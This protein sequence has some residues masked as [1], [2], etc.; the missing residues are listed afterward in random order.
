MIPGI[1]LIYSR[2]SSK[3]LM[4]KSVGRLIYSDNPYKLIVEVDQGISDFYY[5]LI[6][7]S[8]R[9]QKQMYSAHISTIRN[10]I[11]I[12][13]QFWNKY[14]NKLVEFEYESFIYNDE[15][16]YWLNAYSKELENI[17]I[18][19]GLKETSEFTRS[20][21]GLH[22]FHITIANTKHHK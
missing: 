1:L 3:L 14:Q 6:P 22:K 11:P 18:E 17:R 8:H 21:D 12:N 15:T 2:H 13:I 10:E 19:L 7:K 5:S 4:I 20:P 9:V 16:Y